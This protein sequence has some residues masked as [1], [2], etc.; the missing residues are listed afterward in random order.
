MGVWADYRLGADESR[1]DSRFKKQL[2]QNKNKQINPKNII[3]A[4]IKG[5]RNYTA[6]YTRQA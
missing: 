6:K 1:A 4:K 2:L 3:I 5:F